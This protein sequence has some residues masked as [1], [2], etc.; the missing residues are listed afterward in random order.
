MKKLSLILL[1][2]VTVSA[3]SVPAAAAA[4]LEPSWGIGGV[5]TLALSADTYVNDAAWPNR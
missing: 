5:A 4:D 2:L 1:L 3:G